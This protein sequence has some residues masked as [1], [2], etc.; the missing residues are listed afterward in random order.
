MPYDAGIYISLVRIYQI[1]ITELYKQYTKSL[2][3]P[4]TI[5]LLHY[6]HLPYCYSHVGYCQLSGFVKNVCVHVIDTTQCVQVLLCSHW[7]IYYYV[8]P[9]VTNVSGQRLELSL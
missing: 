1:T 9:P 3:L 2:I 5:H 6:I 7:I 8:F 4:Y